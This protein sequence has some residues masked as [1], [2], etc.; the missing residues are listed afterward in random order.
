MFLLF[1][2]NSNDEDVCQCFCFSYRTVTTTASMFVT[3]WTC[4]SFSLDRNGLW[5]HKHS[6]SVFSFLNCCSTPGP[7]PDELKET[8]EEDGRAK[9]KRRKKD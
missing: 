6:R 8:E 2:K 3:V 1:P 5:K 9:K 4:I 7:A